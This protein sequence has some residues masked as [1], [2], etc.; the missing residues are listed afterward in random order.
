M[1][2]E[3]ENVMNGYIVT[4]L[5]EDDLEITK[6]YVVEE[7]ENSEK[8]SKSEFETF[9]HLV[10]LMAELFGIYNS[11]HNEIGYINGLCSE[12]KRFRIMELMQKS[13]RNPK[14]DLGD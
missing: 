11:K 13:L 3:I 6:K 12:N 5:A 10:E 4:I 8:P 7:Q 1:K 2:L 14:N 9:T